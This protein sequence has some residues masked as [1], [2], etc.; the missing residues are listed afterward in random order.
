[1]KVRPWL[2]V[3]AG[4]PTVI[5]TGMAALRRYLRAMGR[6]M[7]AIL[8]F[9]VIRVLHGRFTNALLGVGAIEAFALRGRNP[10][11]KAFRLSCRPSSGPGCGVS[12][13]STQETPGHQGHPGRGSHDLHPRIE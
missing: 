10:E 5:S 6:K 1:M 3:R 12:I 8:S 9:A 4:G 11:A 13:S 2:M 7:A